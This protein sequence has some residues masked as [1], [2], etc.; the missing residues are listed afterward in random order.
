MALFLSKNDD[1]LFLMTMKILKYFSFNTEDKSQILLMLL[2]PT[3]NL[4]G[5]IDLSKLDD[6]LIQQQ[7]IFFMNKIDKIDK[8][9]KKGK[10]EKNS[11]FILDIDKVREKEINE[12]MSLIDLLSSDEEENDEDIDSF[13]KADE[14]NITKQNTNDNKKK[15]TT[16]T[17]PFNF[18][19]CI[20]ILHCQ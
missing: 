1:F 2:D 5:D 15:K 17:T 13:F 12:K 16:S 7:E 9:V 18:E 4:R 19:G 6:E 20:I 8:T 14:E 10:K 11:A 3:S